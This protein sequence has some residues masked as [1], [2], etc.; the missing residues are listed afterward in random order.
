M[1]EWRKVSSWVERLNLYV[2]ENQFKPYEWGV[3]DCV[4]FTMNGVLATTGVDPIPEY[5]ADPWHTKE[6]AMQLL[7][8]EG[9]LIVAMDKRFPRRPNAATFS[10]GD[11]VLIYDAEGLPSL[12]LCTGR[13][14]HAPGETE[15][16]VTPMREAIIVWAVN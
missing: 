8:A 15:L 16:L 9:G 5:R 12:G 1:N 3:L 11:P 4:L 2:M 13:G 7:E 6:E 14:A 10:R